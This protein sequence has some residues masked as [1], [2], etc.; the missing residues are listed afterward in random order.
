VPVGARALH[1]V[2][3]VLVLQVVFVVDVLKPEA[4]MYRDMTVVLI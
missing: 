4:E 3:V 2:V 1:A